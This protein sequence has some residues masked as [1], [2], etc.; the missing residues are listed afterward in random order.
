MRKILYVT[1]TRADF[2]LMA[3]TL[4]RIAAHPLLELQIVVTGMHLSPA[5][6]ETVRDIEALGLPIVARVPTDVDGRTQL[7]MARNVGQALVGLSDAMA[8]ARPDLLLVIGDRGEMLAGALAALH[9]GIPTVHLHGGERSG[10]IDEPVRHAITKISHW[11]FV[12]TEESRQR[13]VRMGERE[14]R[15]WV[16]GAPSLDGLDALAAM[17]RNDVLKQIGLPPGAGYVLV[18]FHPVVQEIAQMRAQTLQ[19][20][21][22]LGGVLAGQGTH[23][24]WLAPNADAGSA[25][26]LGALQE[27]ASTVPVTRVTHM[28]RPLFIAALKQA[29]ALVGNS[30]AGIIETASLGTPVVNIGTRQR[31]RERNLNTLDCGIGGEDIAAALRQALAHGPYPCANRYGDGHAGERIVELLATLPIAPDLLDKVNTY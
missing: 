10:T 21:Q 5:Y 18:L 24:V 6:G 19:L 8:Q 23:V 26:I 2:G 22:A 25:E 14:D 11:H 29:R 4:Q 9:L 27:G 30:S 20:V 1:G 28:A 17:P 3:S 13:I 7:S 16:T 12:A 31:D 15:V